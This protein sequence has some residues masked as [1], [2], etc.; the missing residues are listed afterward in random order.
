VFNIKSEFDGTQYTRDA[1]NFL[2]TF[3]LLV[4]NFFATAL[5]TYK[6]WQVQSCILTAY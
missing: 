2:G 6:L 1:K 5:I 3:G 4:T